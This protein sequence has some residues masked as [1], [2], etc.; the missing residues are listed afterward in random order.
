MNAADRLNMEQKA[1]QLRVMADELM[2]LAPLQALNLKGV[3]QALELRL[4]KLS[5]VAEITVRA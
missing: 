1:R 3:A 5:R 4:S 2:R